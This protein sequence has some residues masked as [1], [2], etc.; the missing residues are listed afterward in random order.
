MR[1][2]PRW[3]LS[4]R[5]GKGKP[6]QVQA[7]FSHRRTAPLLAESCRSS[8]STQVC[9]VAQLP[10]PFGQKWPGSSDQ[11]FKLTELI[12]LFCLECIRKSSQ[13]PLGLSWPMSVTSGQQAV[14]S[15]QGQQPLPL[16]QLSWITKGTSSY[17]LTTR[18]PLCVMG[19]QANL[20]SFF[21]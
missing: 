20:S 21:H 15:S 2:S 7:S 8:C 4:S 9:A 5:E 17:S 6:A 16:A 10:I 18:G 1:Q 13:S 12:W 3:E 11:P 19:S 14:T